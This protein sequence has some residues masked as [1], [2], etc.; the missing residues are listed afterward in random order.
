MGRDNSVCECVRGGG[1][2]REERIRGR[3]CRRWCCVRVCGRAWRTTYHPRQA[4]RSGDSTS[5]SVQL[6]V[7]QSASDEGIKLTTLGCL[8]AGHLNVPLMHWLRS[9]APG[10][11]VIE[12]AGHA[13]HVTDDVAPTVAEYVPKPHRLQAAAPADAAYVPSG[14]R[15]QAAAPRPA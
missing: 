14:H 3:G 5:G 1:C 7:A 10:T 12:L 6:S 4:L 9:V 13:M 2:M 11:D 8:P 15:L